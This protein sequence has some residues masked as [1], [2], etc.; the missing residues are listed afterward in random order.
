MGIRRPKGIARL[1]Q[2]QCSRAPSIVPVGII[3]ATADGRHTGGSLKRRLLASRLRVCVRAPCP[4]REPA[5]RILIAPCAH[6]A[7]ERSACFLVWLHA[8]I[9]T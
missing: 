7:G 1:R 8:G 2:G 5:I 9:A 6:T 3:D 4:P